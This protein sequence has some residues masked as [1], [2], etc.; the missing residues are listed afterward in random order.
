MAKETTNVDQIDV[1]RYG[2]C[3]VSPASSGGGAI[4]S[5]TETDVPCDA[6]V[7]I[8]AVV[9][10]NGAIAEN[11]L[12]TNFPDSKA[13][14]VVVGK[15]AADLCDIQFVGIST[16]IF[17]GLTPSNAYF[18]SAT[19]AG[20]VTSVVPASGTTHYVIKI[21]TAFKSDQLSINIERIVRR[22]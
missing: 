6:S 15:S 17:A 3:N 5:T 21:G 2:D 19:T 14:G 7:Y 11:A 20:Q 22:S 12:A 1:A 18:L 16:S 13:I 8:G 4:G 10:M 9:R